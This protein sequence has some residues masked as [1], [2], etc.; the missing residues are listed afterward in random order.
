MGKKSYLASDGGKMQIK[1]VETKDYQIFNDFAVKFN[2]ETSGLK[3]YFKAWVSIHRGRKVGGISLKKRGKTYLLD[4]IAVDK[5]YQRKG[6]GRRL[7]Q[8]LLNYLKKEG[9]PR[10]YTNT[11][12]PEFFKKF[13]FKKIPRSKSPK[14]SDCWNCPKYNVSCFPTSMLLELRDLKSKKIT[15]TSK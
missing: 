9:I 8:I 7:M 3:D 6:L 5:K 11:V 1:I 14:F 2:L 10:V 12:A 15:G 13:G 4:M